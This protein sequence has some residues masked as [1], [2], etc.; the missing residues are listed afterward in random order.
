MRPRHLGFVVGTFFLPF[1][2]GISQ[3]SEKKSSEYCPKCKL[4]PIPK[5]QLTTYD[6]Q[7]PKSNRGRSGLSAP[8]WSQRVKKL[9]RKPS[10]PSPALAPAARHLLAS[11]GHGGRLER[12][13]R[14][15]QTER[16]AR[17]RTDVGGGK[18]GGGIDGR[19]WRPDRQEKEGQVRHHP[20]SVVA[21]WAHCCAPQGG[22]CCREEAAT[23]VLEKR[24][25]PLR[26]R[27]PLGKGT[28]GRRR[29]SCEVAERRMSSPRAKALY[30]GHRGPW[31][32]GGEGNGLRRRR[33]LA[34]VMVAVGAGSGG[35]KDPSAT[36]TGGVDPA[37]TRAVRRR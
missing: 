28:A 22:C 36:A 31:L 24:V 30:E 25:M 29:A 13:R 4:I 6:P 18:G 9:R 17:R 8:P 20:E 16:R 33:R 34:R 10:R 3:R 15:M 7:I 5:S 23:T 26:G 14:C 35:S 12:R 32:T 19:G 21:W 37:S 2:L 1:P 11:P 27:H